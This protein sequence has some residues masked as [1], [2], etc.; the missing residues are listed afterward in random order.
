MSLLIPRFKSATGTLPGDVSFWYYRL[1][2]SDN[3]ALKTAQ[4]GK[5]GPFGAQLWAANPDYGFHQAIFGSL[6]EWDYNDSNAVVSTG[7]ASAHAE[8]ENLN[9]EKRSAVTHFLQDHKNKGWEVVQI[10][11]G[12]SCPSCRSKQVLLAQ[13][14]IDAEYIKPG[15]FYVPFKATYERTKIDAGFND[16]P[17]DTTFR[18]INALGVL[19]TD[20]SLLNLRDRLSQSPETK[21]LVKAGKLI[22]T[23]VIESANIPLTIERDLTDSSEQDIPYAAIVS[24][25][26]EVLSSARD[27]RR[28]QK[29]GINEF[30]KTAIVVALQKAWTYQ[31][32]ERGIFESWNLKKARLITNIADIGPLAYAE[33]LWANL[34]TIEIAGN[35]PEIDKA[36]RE[37]PSLSNTDLFKMVAADYNTHP[38]PLTAVHLG[39]P[40]TPNRS[41]AAWRDIV[42]KRKE[43][44]DVNSHY[45][46]A[47]AAPAQQHS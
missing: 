16:E 10:S 1:E 41:H 40:Y 27:E 36:A 22:W 46:G 34:S 35:T 24:A 21:E 4:S 15:Q 12:E 44:E 3:F 18:A 9:I 28:N 32:E 30:E 13:E 23:P 31:R 39:D 42:R 47:Q 25:E 33:S 26:G 45:D 20:G 14:L 5:G 17:Y 19:D 38:S 8:A 29:G 43:K 7:W 11:S 37:L 6:N 2:E